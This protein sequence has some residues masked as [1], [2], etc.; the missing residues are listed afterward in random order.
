MFG[1]TKVLTG[2]VNIHLKVLSKRRML[3]K[4]VRKCYLN[5]DL[6]GNEA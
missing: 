3:L 1:I 2:Y 4:E 6:E 5:E